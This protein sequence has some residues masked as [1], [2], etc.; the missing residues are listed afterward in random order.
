MALG[1]LCPQTV[2]RK[3]WYSIVQGSEYQLW[4]AALYR[5]WYK[6]TTAVNTRKSKLL[7]LFVFGWKL[8]MPNVPL[9]SHFILKASWHL[10]SLMDKNFH[11]HLLHLRNSNTPFK[12]VF[13]A[14]IDILLIGNENSFLWVRESLVEWVLVLP[15]WTGH[16][17]QSTNWE[18]Q[19]Q[20]QSASKELTPVSCNLSS[21][22][23]DH[24][25]PLQSEK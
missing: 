20:H 9:R 1:T 15:E 25:P 2:E 10:C 6:T 18:S 24:K 8:W 14:L 16:C 22:H 23:L 7:Q 19:R 4:T 3:D 17:G 5:W 21:N 12:D 13:K 11:F